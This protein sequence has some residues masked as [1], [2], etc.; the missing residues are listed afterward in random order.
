[1]P[2]PTFLERARDRLRHGDSDSAEQLL[3]AGLEASPESVVGWCSLA[4]ALTRRRAYEEALDA[5]SRALALAP[6][7]PRALISRAR[8][9]RAFGDGDAAVEAL[10]L[11]VRRPGL[12]PAL[13]AHGLMELGQALD[14]IGKVD[15]A[16]TTIGLGQQIRRAL[17]VA[18]GLRSHWLAAHL[19]AMRHW[20]DGRRPSPQH[21]WDDPRPRPIFLVGVPR[22]GATLVQR[23]LVAA[24]A[25]S[26][27]ERPVLAQA[28]ADAVESQPGVVYPGELD[29]WSPTMVQDV[30]DR[31][32]ERA[33]FDEGVRVL[34]KLPLDLV[35]VGAIHRCFAGAPVIQV[36]RDPRDTLLSGYFQNFLLNP[37]MVEWTDPRRLA[38]ATRGLLELGD[39]WGSELDGLTLRVQRYE[40]L[41]DD[42]DTEI[43]ALVEHAGLQGGT[44]TEPV[45]RRARGRWRRYERQLGPVLP[46]LEPLRSRL[47]FA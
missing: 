47:R 28:I 42:P 7:D 14:Q 5:S 23:I 20:L 17:A 6:G 12:P 18:Q 33:G 21:P 1:M 4:D 9:L 34:H 13:R 31:F 43:A 38:E 24:G 8:T 22:S 10:A 37:A 15:E 46:L 19:G 3:R 44:V 40:R 30:R 36:L 16:W 39:R 45:H 11:A 35:H 32:F 41:V 25:Q 2:A 29:R 26:T 27:S